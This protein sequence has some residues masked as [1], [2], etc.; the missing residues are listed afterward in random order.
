M[1]QDIETRDRVQQSSGPQS[2][3]NSAG[4]L[5]GFK[6]GNLFGVEIAVDWSLLIIFGLITFSLGGGL[7]PSWHPNW[8]PA[9]VWG[10]ALGAALLFFVSVLI[11]ELSHALVARQ[12]GIPVRRVTL[13]LFG[14]IAH[15]SREPDSPRAEFWIAIVGPI[16]S[17]VIGVLATLLGV[18]L[19][20]E[21]LAEAAA[22]EEPAAMAQAL[23]SVGPVA[24]LL[25]WLGP[26]NITLALFNLVPGF[27]LDGGR[28]LR[29]ILWAITRDLTKATRWA[30]RAGQGF[31]LLLVA[32]GLVDIMSGAFG[33]GLWLILIAWFL[34]NAAKVSY[35]QLMVRQ[36]LQA[37]PVEQVMRTRLT[38]IPPDL[39]LDVFVRDYI[40]L[41]DQQAFPVELDGRLL[42]L[43]RLGDVKKLPQVEWP[44]STVA[45]V[46]T[47]VEEL[48]S[49]PPNAGAERA[50]EELAER[51]VD[52]LP[53]VERQHVIGLVGR[54][55]LMKWLALKTGSKLPYPPTLARQR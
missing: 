52:Q 20:G 4:G 14:G 24:T 51:D 10:V 53:V 31:A 5:E 21:A 29:S 6:L 46:M 49:L 30:S 38:R 55:D 35:Q 19:G 23:Q 50:L 15:M 28:V 40:M 27:P 17:I 3:S 48:S 7:F 36:A 44:E 32:W 26:I 47:P 43:V 34:N 12:Q 42:G 54:G 41:S 1:A 2:E 39:P 33:S 9:M 45:Q 13:F 22:T 11:H 8:S 16:S 37:V 25:L 18:S